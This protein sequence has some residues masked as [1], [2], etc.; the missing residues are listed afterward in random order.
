MSD[1]QLHIESR[2][3]VVNHRHHLMSNGEVNHHNNTIIEKVVLSPH[4]L[5]LILEKA[6]REDTVQNMKD[7]T[8]LLDV[9]NHHREIILKGFLHREV[10]LQR[11]IR[12]QV[13]LI[14]ERENH[15]TIMDMEA[16]LLHLDQGT[17]L[18]LHLIV[19]ILL[20]VI[21]MIGLNEAAG[22][23]MDLEG[24][25]IFCILKSLLL[26]NLVLHLAIIKMIVDHPLL[27]VE[28]M[29]MIHI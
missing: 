10:I 22:M 3:R 4:D 26:I 8:R 19:S 2:L 25:F 13:I 23:I 24:K 27:D 18:I 16:D 6:Q 29:I 14:D 21:M 11:I 5:D 1:S 9:I 12:Q 17:L 20:L 28:V 15:H 7:I